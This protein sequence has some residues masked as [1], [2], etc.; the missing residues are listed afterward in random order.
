MNNGRNCDN[1][2]NRLDEDDFDSYGSWSYECPKCGFNYSHSSEMSLD[3]Q[4]ESQF[5]KIDAEFDEDE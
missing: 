5:G 4:L 3:E 1:C 2:D